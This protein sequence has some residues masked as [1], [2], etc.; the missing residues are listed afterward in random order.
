VKRILHALGACLVVVAT[1]LLSAVGPSASA[2]PGLFGPDEPTPPE[3]GSCH[4]MTLREFGDVVDPD[5]PVA[6]DGR[7]TS[8][9]FVVAE[10][11]AD[12]DLGDP[13]A[14]ALW[15]VDRCGPVYR[16][17]INPDMRKRL[18]TSYVY[19]F[20]VPTAAE[21]RDGGR[22]VRCDLALHGGRTALAPLPRTVRVPAVRGATPP[23]AEARCYVGKKL[24][25]TVCARP[26]HYRAK[27]VFEMSGRAYPTDRTFQR[28]VG[29]RCARA[30]DARRWAYLR[31]S[32][33][34]WRSGFRYVTCIDVTRR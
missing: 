6:C 12:L 32:E 10:P 21:Q 26:H 19:G 23:D 2:A 9:T 11:P 14:V 7:H 20:F 1:T 31:P 34:E 15:A 30:S 22:W 4:A 25:L 28:A 3:V 17:A 13:D 5:E 29:R 8:R 33:Q 27:A 18:M 16:R 24:Y